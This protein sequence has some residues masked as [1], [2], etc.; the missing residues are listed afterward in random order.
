MSPASAPVSSQP[1]MPDPATR[2]G[3]VVD[4]ESAQEFR[5]EALTRV[6]DTNLA[7]IATDLQRKS[8]SLQQLLVDR[9]AD[10]DELRRALRWVFSTR[11][12]A[13]ALVETIGADA[14][15]DGVA[16]LLGSRHG[17]AERF[18]R[19]AELL[20]PVPE[21][22]AD[23]PGELLHFTAP[24][25]YWLWTRWM[26]DP[27]I[28]TGALRLVTT[29]DVDLLGDTPGQT[30]LRVGQAVAFVDQT[31]KAAGFTDAGPGLFG[32]DVFLAAVYGV[33]MNTVLRMRMTQEFNRLVPELP[34]LIRRLLGVYHLE[35]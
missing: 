17:V 1:P 5:A 21:A 11:R 24:D 3:P 23:L 20:A 4:T 10:R 9:R 18:D 33:Y 22:A 29:E 19:F 34:S 30:Y 35:G 13:D 31:G 25:R 26:W 28:E 7:A 14:L 32:L 8:A 16:D 6:P 15:S 27:Q 2:P 12:R